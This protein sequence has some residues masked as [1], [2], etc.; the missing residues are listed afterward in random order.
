MKTRVSDFEPLDVIGIGNSMNSAN[1]SD[2][3]ALKDRLEF[4][5][6]KFHQM[7]E[8][9]FKGSFYQ[10]LLSEISRENDGAISN[11][12]ISQN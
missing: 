12:D 5:I 7:N 1:L 4:F 3:I 9:Q 6:E 10:F 2:F 11:M 8:M